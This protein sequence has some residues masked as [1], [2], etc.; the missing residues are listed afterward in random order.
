M[1]SLGDSIHPQAATNTIQLTAADHHLINAN[2]AEAEQCELRA[3]SSAPDHL[4]EPTIDLPRLSSTVPP[5]PNDLY[6]RMGGRMA[7]SSAFAAMMA[8]G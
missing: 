4:R 8:A 7:W 3:H 1:A 5:W 2:H 6:K